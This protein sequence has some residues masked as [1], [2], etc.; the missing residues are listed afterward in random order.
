[1][2]RF[3]V[4]P[5]T[6]STFCWSSAVPSVAVTSAC[7]SPRVNTAEPCVAR[8]HADFDRDRA[9]LVELAAVEPLAALEDLVAQD[10]LLQ[11]LED[12]LGFDLPLDLAFGQAGDQVCEH[13]V[14]RAVVLELVLDPH[15]V[16]ERHEDLL[17]DLAVEL[18]ADLLLRDRGLLRLAGLLR[19]AR[20]C[21]R[22]SP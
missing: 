2:K 3:H 9:D 4:S 22:R 18:L 10:L 12:R 13:L 16:G 15:R 6:V 8:Q 5:S 14:D 20:R 7:V 21:R 11:L 19:P 17:F 1:M